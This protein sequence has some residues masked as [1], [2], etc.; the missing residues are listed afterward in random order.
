MRRAS[1]EI[2]GFLKRPDWGYA[3]LYFYFY[4]T[5]IFI[6][7]IYSDL[8]KFYLPWWQISTKITETLSPRMPT[9]A[10]R[11]K[12]ELENVAS[13]RQPED[14]FACLPLFNLPVH[15]G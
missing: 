11:I 6:V 12:A 13:V 7:P 4:S 5:Y 1:A 10:L 2:Q 15:L 8:L 14:Q 9:F 3:R